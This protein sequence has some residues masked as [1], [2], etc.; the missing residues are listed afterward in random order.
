MPIAERGVSRHYGK[1]LLSHSLCSRHEYTSDY[2]TGGIARSHTNVLLLMHT[3]HSFHF[4]SLGRHDNITCADGWR[5]S[6]PM[7][8]LL[9]LVAVP[10]WHRKKNMVYCGRS[11]LNHGGH[12]HDLTL[13]YITT[14]EVKASY[15]SNGNRAH[16]SN[17]ALPFN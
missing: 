4:T 12:Q 13:L 14:D 7:A 6:Q 10:C 3:L 1:P 9:G 11:T 17:N 5:N 2:H 8:V 15:S 16:M